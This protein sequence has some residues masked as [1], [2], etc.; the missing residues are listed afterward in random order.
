M[1]DVKDNILAFPDGFETIVGERGIT[2][3]GG[4][5][6]RI[7]IARALIKNPEILILDDCLSAVDTSTET[8]ILKN[9]EKILL[10][11]TAIFIS[12]RVSSLKHANH[13]IV[14][15]DGHIIEQGNHQT[16]INNNGFYAQAFIKQQAEN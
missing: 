10:N 14:L 5:K 13:I 8:K 11:K 2:L 7:A 4:Q 9:L 15:D 6:Q 1:A 3:S 16:L 12:H